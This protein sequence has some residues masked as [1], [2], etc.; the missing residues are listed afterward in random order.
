MRNICRRLPPLAMGKKGAFRKNET[1]S[2][3][4]ESVAICIKLCP[5]GAPNLNEKRIRP[6]G[7]TKKDYL[8]TMRL[9]FGKTAPMPISSRRYGVDCARTIPILK[10]VDP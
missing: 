8:R 2:Q 1:I 3:P 4:I 10:N 5:A 7:C 6:P 9:I